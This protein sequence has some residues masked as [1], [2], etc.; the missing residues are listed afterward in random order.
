VNIQALLQIDPQF[1]EAIARSVEELRTLANAQGALELPVRLQERTPYVAPDMQYVASKVITA[2]AVHA[3]DK[4]L[5]RG[6]SDEPEPS[7]TGQTLPEGAAPSA[8]PDPEDPADLLGQFL[9]RAL[10]RRN[11]EPAAPQPSH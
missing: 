3:I 11:P 6:E 8:E 9:N 5:R 10:E 4:L 2:T 7:G 1:S